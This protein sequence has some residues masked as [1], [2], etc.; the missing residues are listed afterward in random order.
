MLIP[1]QVVGLI[2]TGIPPGPLL[3]AQT[4]VLEVGY[5]WQ[6]ATL[7]E[8]DA[9]RQAE[10]RA[11]RMEI[12]GAAAMILENMQGRN[13]QARM[14][15]A[16]TMTGYTAVAIQAPTVIMIMHVSLMA[17]LLRL[18]HLPKLTVLRE[19]GMEAMQ[20]NLTAMQ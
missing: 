10:M 6:V 13:P 19:P 1:T 16:D 9:V 7:R 2:W 17:G 20:D 8:K 15:R 18:Q 14:P 11:T 4:Y 12:T 5:T 3:L